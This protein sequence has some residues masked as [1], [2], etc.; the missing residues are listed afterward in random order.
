MRA[1]L[2]DEI[3]PSDMRKV[4]GFLDKN[5]IK[6]HIDQVFWVP[7][8]DDLLSDIQLEHHHCQP[9]VFSVEL[10]SDWIKLEFFVRSLKGIHCTCLGYCTAKQRDY[11][12]RFS[13]GMIEQLG[14]RT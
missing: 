11:I 9:H 2:I 12:I 4:I 13:H 7:I 10:G 14:I 8:P 3:A 6:S 5:T 1:Y